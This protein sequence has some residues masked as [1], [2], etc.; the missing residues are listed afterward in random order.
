M[1][2]LFKQ[3]LILFWNRILLVQIKTDEENVTLTFWKYIIFLFIVQP[4][5]IIL[6]ENKNQK[7][8]R[9]RKTNQTRLSSHSPTVDAYSKY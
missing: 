1:F 2:V 7:N 6:T 9:K 3:V 4:I 8:N 5:F